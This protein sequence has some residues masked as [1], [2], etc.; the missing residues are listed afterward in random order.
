M[1]TADT[2]L[3]SDRVRAV[4]DAAARHSASVAADPKLLSSAGSDG[5]RR[6]GFGSGGHGKSTRR[7]E[8]RRLVLGSGVFVRSLVHFRQ[9]ERIYR[10]SSRGAIRRFF[11]RCDDIKR[12]VNF[13]REEKNPLLIIYSKCYPSTTFC[14]VMFAVT[15]HI[16][17]DLFSKTL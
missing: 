12:R 3:G 5:H 6:N 16:L 1:S 8:T 11:D 2:Q 4:S 9:R 10:L 15:R 13:G 17:V 7:D 14:L